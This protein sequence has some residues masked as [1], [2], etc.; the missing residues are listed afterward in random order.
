METKEIL[1]KSAKWLEENGW[2]QGEFCFGSDDCPTACCLIGVLNFISTGNARHV[3]DETN[4][5]RNCIHNK[6][7]K[8]YLIYGIDSW[9]DDEKRKKQE[10]IDL[11]E[12][13]AKL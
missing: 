5:A 3:N 7:D 4:L 9:N 11:L 2:C 6:L 13:A 10:V 8:K 12:E 1:L